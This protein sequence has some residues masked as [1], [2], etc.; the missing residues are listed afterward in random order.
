MNET[1]DYLFCVQFEAEY[2]DLF[3]TWWC[4]SCKRADLSDKPKQNHFSDVCFHRQRLKTAPGSVRLWKDVKS[5]ASVQKLHVVLVMLWFSSTCQHDSFM[6]T[7]KENVILKNNLCF[8]R[9]RWTDQ[10]QLVYD[11]L[12]TEAAEGG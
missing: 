9:K 8:L 2:F 10:L 3:S 1:V 11:L 7:I 5:R 12:K 4:D 6:E